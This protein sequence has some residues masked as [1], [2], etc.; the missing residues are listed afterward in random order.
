[1]PH[2]L[3][4]SFAPFLLA[5]LTPGMVESILEGAQPVD[6]TAARLTGRISLPINWSE[7]HRL[8]FG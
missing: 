2:L 4:R 7:Q 6:L 5:F 1:M 8:I 3:V